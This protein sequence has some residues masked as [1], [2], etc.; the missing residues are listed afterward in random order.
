MS[1][2]NVAIVRRAEEALSVSFERGE[3][4][5]DLLD[6]CAPDIRVDASRRIFN[7]AVYDGHDGLRRLIRE[8]SEAW[9]DFSEVNDRHIDAGQQV[10][11][12]QRISA[13]GRES[14]AQVQ[15]PAAL[16]WTMREGRIVR[17]DIFLDQEEALDVA[18]L[19]D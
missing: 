5:A 14:R 12:L 19:K 13:R 8:I 10:V 4:T 9:E 6:L 17:V 3:A 1:Q 11:A 2:E 16:I 18:G 15:A 7:P